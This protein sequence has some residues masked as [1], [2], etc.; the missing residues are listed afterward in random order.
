ML[1]RSGAGVIPLPRERAALDRAD[2]AV[3]A[4]A[5]EVA[6]VSTLPPHVLLGLQHGMTPAAAAEQMAALAAVAPAVAG[7]A[8]A[9]LAVTALRLIA[10]GHDDPAR[11][12]GHTLQVVAPAGRE[13]T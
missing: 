13:W 1:R 2:A 5:V 12:A 7:A 4:A 8:A 10:D 11:L 6:P 3:C 9:Q